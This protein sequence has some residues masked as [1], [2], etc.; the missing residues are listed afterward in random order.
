MSRLVATATCLTAI[1][2]MV[3]IAPAA[4]AATPAQ[5]DVMFVFDT[6]GSMSGVLGEAKEEIETV[7]NQV[8]ASVPNV[9]FGVAN[10]EDYP[11]YD[12]GV[13]YETKSEQEYGEDPEKPWR[14]DQSVTTEQSK[15]VAAIE[16]LS[17]STV[18]HG[19]GDAPEAYGRALWETDTNPQVDWR[20]GARHEIILIADEV[21]HTPNVNEGIPEAFWLENPFDTHEEQPGGWGIPGTVWQPGDDTNFQADLR[22]LTLDGKPLEMV[23]YHDTSGDYVHY[24]EHWA[25]ETG[26]QAIEAKENE[27]ESNELSN[28]LITQIK[29]GTTATLPLARRERVATTTKCVLL[30]HPSRF[31]PAP[32]IL[33]QA[34]NP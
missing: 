27:K 1:A 17:G 14:L 25:G 12:E 6:S 16:A 8:S 13:L 24:W 22:Q 7:I 26:G 32:Q 30:P 23:D 33:S 21:P 4:N 9:A 10:V 31:P 20:P 19:G 5:T 2:V 29:A 18:A 28:R 11:S 34:N 3:S 15:V